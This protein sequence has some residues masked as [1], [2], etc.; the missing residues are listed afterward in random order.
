MAVPLYPSFP[1]PT[2][3]PLAPP[4]EGNETFLPFPLSTDDSSE[5]YRLMH[6]WH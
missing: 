2:V 5:P 3:S 6:P 1:N 4:K